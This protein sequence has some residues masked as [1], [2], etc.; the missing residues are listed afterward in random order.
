[1]NDS[2][3]MKFAR[4]VMD[5]IDREYREKNPCPDCGSHNVDHEIIWINGPHVCGDEWCNDCGWK[6]RTIT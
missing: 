1:M 2:E 6:E 4:G 3:A 5:R